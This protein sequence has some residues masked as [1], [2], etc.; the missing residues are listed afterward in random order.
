MTLSGRA[1]LERPDIDKLEATPVATVVHQQRQI[2]KAGGWRRMSAAVGR[3]PGYVD[4]ETGVYES[5]TRRM[6]EGERRE[7]GLRR[8]GRSRRQRK[9]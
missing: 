2:G 1:A 5:P 3:T 7:A 9:L 8:N 4:P 6:T